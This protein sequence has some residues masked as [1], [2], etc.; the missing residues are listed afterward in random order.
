M[1]CNQGTEVFTPQGRKSM[2]GSDGLAG[3]EVEVEELHVR[4]FQVDPMQRP[5]L[6][7][8]REG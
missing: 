6:Y 4:L 1:G 7:L 8:E 5:Q 3:E 2:D